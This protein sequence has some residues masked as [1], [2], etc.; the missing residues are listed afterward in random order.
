MVFHI[1]KIVSLSLKRQTQTAPDLLT[2]VQVLQLFSNEINLQKFL[3]QNPPPDI[4][5]LYV[6]KM[7]SKILN[8]NTGCQNFF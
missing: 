6:Q 1:L 4:T 3:W 5:L 7:R 2:C 8:S